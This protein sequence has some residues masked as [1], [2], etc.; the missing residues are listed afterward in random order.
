MILKVKGEHKGIHVKA[1][2]YCGE[3]SGSLA[4]CG[5]L[6]MKEEEYKTFCATLVKGSYIPPTNQVEIKLEGYLSSI[7]FQ[8]EESMDEDEL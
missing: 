1:T 8:D 3:Q 5:D 6:C 2:L 7:E 4:N